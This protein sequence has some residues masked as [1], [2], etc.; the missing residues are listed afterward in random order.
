MADANR[1]LA[2]TGWPQVSTL[3]LIELYLDRATEA[4]SALAVLA[5][6]RPQDFA[7]APVIQA[8]T[9]ALRRPPDSGYRGA[10][11][12]FITAVQRLGAQQQPV[13]EFT[14]DTQRARTEVRGQATQPRLVD[15]MVRIGADAASTDLQV[16][17]TLFQLLVPVE[18]EP[19]LSGSTSVVL[20]LDK[21]TARLP[22]ELLDAGPTRTAAPP[23]SGPGR[24]A[25]RLLRKLRTEEFRDRPVGAGRDGGVL[26]IG[27]PLCDPTK[28]AD[29]PRPATRR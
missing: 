12:D 24:C 10:S 4:H 21:S 11:Y 1:R 6:S 28:F 19:F 3:Q 18:I 22:W 16:R 23:T 13:I 20:E 25:R 15:E 9:G 5:E 2:R 8:R 17:R 7:L 14:L 29:C 26:V 27:E